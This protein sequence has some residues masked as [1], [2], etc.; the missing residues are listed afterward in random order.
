MHH[1]KTLKI[2][3]ND[4]HVNL[5]GSAIIAQGGPERFAQNFTTFFEHNTPDIELVSI[6]FSDNEKKED[7]YIRKTTSSHD[8]YEVVFPKQKLH[9]NYIKSFTKVAFL[10]LLQPWLE[11][12]DTVFEHAKPDIVFLNGFNISSWFILETAYRRGVPVCIQHA[13]IAKKEL[14]VSQR[15]FSPSMRRILI[16]FEKEIIKKSAHQI[17]LNEYSRDVFFDIHKTPIDVHIQKKISI[18]PLPIDIK[19]IV[20]MNLASKFEYNIGMVARWD[21]IKNHRAILRLA[22]FIKNK[23]LPLILEVVTKWR[24]DVVSNFRDRYEKIVTVVPQMLPDKLHHFFEK[25]DVTV[26]PSNFDV[27]PTVLMES[28]LAGT[29]AVIS[30]KV[31]WVSDYHAFGLSDMIIPPT[32]SGQKIV[33]TIE[34]LIQDKTIYIPRFQKLQQKIHKDHNPKNVF[35]LYY[36]IFKHMK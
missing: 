3:C 24:A 21:S 7:I 4:Y 34:K 25:Q 10:K 9:E 28:L 8:F 33:E 19:H 13:G 17:F 5:P 36:Q 32:A 6:L 30:N 20:P 31:G 26:I 18:V 2:L 14:I 23:K 29:P 12:V 11:Q 35:P 1:K 27:S 22:T 16:G 15:H